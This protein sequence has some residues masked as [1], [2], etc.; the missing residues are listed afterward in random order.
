MTY[1]SR[2]VISAPP[3]PGGGG[4]G[5]DPASVVPYCETD[6]GYVGHQFFQGARIGV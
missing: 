1:A 4:V 3:P 5:M 2:C 6:P